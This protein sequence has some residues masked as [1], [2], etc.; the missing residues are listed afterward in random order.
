[1]LIAKIKIQKTIRFMKKLLLSFLCNA[2]IFNLLGAQNAAAADTERGMGMNVVIAVIAII[3][4]GIIGF[5]IHLDRK[6]S[7]LEKDNA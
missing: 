1:M 3:F 7:R 2:L 6:I 4:V 5:L